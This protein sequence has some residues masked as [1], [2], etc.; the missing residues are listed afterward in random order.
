MSLASGYRR[1]AVWRAWPRIFEA[2]PP[3][4][5]QTVLDLGCGVGDQAAEL[6]ARGAR[7]IGVDGN[8]ELLSRARARR[9]AGAEF[10]RSNLQ[11]L[12]G[13]DVTADGI[14]SSF[15]AAYF[16]DLPPVLASWRRRL[17][18]G[19]WIA[20]TEIDNLFGH[21]PLGDTRSLLEAYAADAFAAGRYDFHM[22]GRLPSH[23]KTS[24]FTVTREFTVEDLELSFAGP[25]RADVL[26]AWSSRFERMP[27]LRDFCGPEFEPLRRDFLD[28]L[29][30]ADHR[31]LATVRSCMAAR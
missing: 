16:P 3:L 24:G 11:T 27:L 8:E 20:L 9:L 6:E 12:S 2:L 19:G 7:V 15:A 10:H 30:R 18:P 14:W 25:A 22:G 5:G 26:E 29:A 17:R 31:S 1:Q 21:E 13:L 28:C 4:G 23:L